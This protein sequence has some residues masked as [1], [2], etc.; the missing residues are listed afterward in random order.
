MRG[1]SSA[2][3]AASRHSD[4]V[5]S[6]YLHPHFWPRGPLP[7]SADADWPGF[8]FG[9]YTWTIQTYLR[10]NAAGVRCQLVSTLPERGIVLAHRESLSAVDGKF[11]GRV[12]PRRDLFIVDICADLFPYPLA[13]AHIVQNPS[14]T[15]FGKGFLY[16]PHWTQ[17]ALVPRRA[18]RGDA[19]ENAVYIGN[20]KNL[21]PDLRTA[22]WAEELASMGIRW[23]SHY[24]IFRYDD[25]STY[26]TSSRWNDYG[27]A[28]VVIAVRSFG[29][30]EARYVHKPASKLYNAWH[31]G[32]PVILGKESAYQLERRSELDYLEAGSRAEVL[33]HLAYLKNNPAA[34]RAMV[35]NGRKRAQ[36]VDA[37]ATTQRWVSLL[38][39]TISP[40]YR[41][42]REQ[43]WLG[44]FGSMTGQWRDYGKHTI[45]RRVARWAARG[46]DQE[47]EPSPAPRMLDG[48]KPPG[49]A[50]GEGGRL[51]AW[52]S[53]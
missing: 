51:G 13:N 11:E 37:S 41:E 6:F 22:G 15:L 8:G 52:V 33:Q 17:P 53:Y 9:P 27:D 28:D 16:V 10:L 29:A 24:Q 32:I 12:L 23:R 7:S 38:E 40:A 36:E 25:P 26:A 39:D 47:T 4:E 43:G 21:P 48:R 20:E 30:G 3:E 50:A 18:D 2:K 42:W 14:M 19:F 46:R 35:E 31:A 5:Y 44:R 34:R 49:R 1:R 45:E